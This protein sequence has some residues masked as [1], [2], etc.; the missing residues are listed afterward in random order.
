MLW[1]NRIIIIVRLF[2][3]KIV[4]LELKEHKMTQWIQ[5]EVCDRDA[6]IG[7]I[8]EIGGYRVCCYCLDGIQEESRGFLARQI[9][10]KIR[11]RKEWE[12]EINNNDIEGFYSRGLG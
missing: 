9:A 8:Y 3:G 12:K 1:I 5:C 4:Y 11:G 6:N 7:E 10:R 2:E